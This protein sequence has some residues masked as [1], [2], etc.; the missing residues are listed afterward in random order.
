MAHAFSPSIYEAEESRLLWVRD[1]PGLPG[2]VPGQLVLLQKEILSWIPL[3]KE[4]R[5]FSH[6]AYPNYFF[7]PLQPPIPS[8]FT[9][10]LVFIRKQTVF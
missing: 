1:N 7:F 4:Y 8:G 9:P 5:Y 6:I 2:Q 10:F 3:A